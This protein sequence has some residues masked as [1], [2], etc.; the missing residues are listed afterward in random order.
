MRGISAIAGDKTIRLGEAH[1]YKIAGVHNPHESAKL[2]HAQWKLSVRENGH[3]RELKAKSPKIGK[4]VSF[5]IGNPKLAGKTLLI[6]AYLYAPEQKAPPGLVVK[7]TGEAGYIT[8]MEVAT[9]NDEKGN[10]KKIVATVHTKYMASKKLKLSVYEADENGICDIKKQ[11][12]VETAYITV[13]KTEISTYI[14]LLNQFIKLA[15]QYRG[16]NSDQAT[17]YCVVAECVEEKETN[18]KSNV[19]NPDYPRH[20]T[21]SDPKKTNE[22]VN[23]NTTRERRVKVP[24]SSPKPDPETE[25]SDA[26]VGRK[27]D[28]QNSEVCECEARVRA[29]LRMLRVGE[30]TGEIIETKRGSGIYRA[31]NFDKGYKRGF[32]NN[33]IDLSK[34][35]DDAWQGSSAKGAYQVMRYKYWE[36]EGFEVGHGKNGYFNT[37]IYHGGSDQLKKFNIKRDYY[38]ETQDKIGVL[39]LILRRALDEKH[40]PVGNPLIEDIINGDIEQAIKKKGALEWASLPEDGYNSH[41]TYHGKPQPATP[42]NKC[43][44]HYHKFLADELNNK[45]PLHLQKGFL[46]EFKYYCCGDKPTPKPTEI[47]TNSKWH[48]PLKRMELRGWYDTGWDP[49]KSKMGKHVR[50]IRKH[51]GLDLYAPMGTPIYACVDGIVSWVYWSK[52]YGNVIMLK[53]NY[54]STTY[55]FFHAH[56]QE[57]SPLHDGDQVIGGKTIIGYTGQSGS[58]ARRLTPRMRHLHF[59]VKTKRE[60]KGFQLNPFTAISELERDVNKNPDRS[61]QK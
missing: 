10:G 47:E 51:D 25:I 56:M 52:S 16:A 31:I 18:A 7:V 41:F 2:H 38:P 26:V 37:N 43:L 9:G 54:L 58:S 4:E 24:S 50:G 6:E 61:T 28:G 22:P 30:G 33:V 60:R 8:S 55:Y 3:W 20:P 42:L 48:N 21:E 5:I 23:N 17:E 40:R 44:E 45:S 36:L 32:G 34:Y 59:E 53:G 15:N 19:A 27:S 1:V 11:Q 14:F 35:S 46:K 49:N 12:P 13:N 39:L 29:F 57:R